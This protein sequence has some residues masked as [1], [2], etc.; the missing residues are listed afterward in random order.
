MRICTTFGFALIIQVF[1]LGCHHRDHY[2]LIEVDPFIA[3]DFRSSLDDEGWAY[4]LEYEDRLL[5]Y[6]N[7]KTLHT[8]RLYQRA[9][10]GMNELYQ[11]NSQIEKWDLES[12]EHRFPEYK[13]M[14]PNLVGGFG[15]EAC[16]ANSGLAIRYDPYHPYA[17]DRGLVYSM[18]CVDFCNDFNL[19]FCQEKIS[20][21]DNLESL[22][23]ESVTTP[24]HIIP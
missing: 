10:I 3:D 4:F 18:R 12:Q 15:L 5:V 23:Q 22:I 21:A 17:S 2:L 19:R 24:S 8:V 20:I 6:P 16:E 7:Q 11:A 14:H 1:A 9:L 13:L